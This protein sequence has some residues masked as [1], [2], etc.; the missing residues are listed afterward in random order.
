M[1]SHVPKWPE[2]SILTLIDP[3]K[4]AHTLL[5]D[6]VASRFVSGQKQLS[7]SIS[8]MTRLSDELEWLRARVDVNEFIDLPMDSSSV[9]ILAGRTI[10]QYFT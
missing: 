9:I 8:V 7:L 3:P 10:P 1:I 5:C 4:R 2:L 6:M